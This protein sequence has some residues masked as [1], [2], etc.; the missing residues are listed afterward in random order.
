MVGHDD[1]GACIGEDREHAAPIPFRP[2]PFS[3]VACDTSIKH[4]DLAQDLIPEYCGQA[5]V[6]M[7]PIL[8]QKSNTFFTLLFCVYPTRLAPGSG[9][10]DYIDIHFQK[11]GN[12][13]HLSPQ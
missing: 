3:S 7:R 8:Y 5:E 9:R 10:H 1:E 4:P 12:I 6:F 11:Y 13:S 2:G